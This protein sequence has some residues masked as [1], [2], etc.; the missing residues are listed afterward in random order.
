MCVLFIKL[1]QRLVK[2]LSVIVCPHVHS[3]AAVA[4][5]EDLS[6]K[7]CCVMRDAKREITQNA[8]CLDVKYIDLN[9]H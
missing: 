2:V 5:I 8:K 1:L 3:N 4:N 6:T 7:T 9:F